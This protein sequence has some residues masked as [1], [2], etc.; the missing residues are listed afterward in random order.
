MSLSAGQVEAAGGLTGAVQHPRLLR[1][2]LATRSLQ[3]WSMLEGRP[4]LRRLRRQGWG[5][6]EGPYQV[7]IREARIKGAALLPFRVPG[8]T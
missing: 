3:V 6:K 4:G 7:A 1:G 8:P 2:L 5:W